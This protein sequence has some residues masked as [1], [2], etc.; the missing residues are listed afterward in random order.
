MTPVK[1]DVSLRSDAE[2]RGGGG[3]RSGGLSSD[4]GLSLDL[5]STISLTL[6]AFDKR[7]YVDLI[8]AR[9]AAL[10]RMVRQ[11]A[12]AMGLASAVDAG[13]G[14]GFFAQTLAEMGL[15]VRGFDGRVENVMEARRRFPEIAF[16]RGDVESAEIADFGKFDLVLCFGLLYHLENPMR[17]IRNLRALTGK[18]LLVESMCV[19][20]DGP[21][22]TLREEPSQDDQSLTD[23]AFYPSEDCLVKMLYRAGFANVY[24]LVRLPEHDDF[25]ETADHSRRRTMLLATPGSVEAPCVERIAEPRE[26]RDPWTKLSAEPESLALRVRRFLEKPGRMRYISLANR[27][28]RLFP[29]M[30]IPLRLPFGA[31]WLAENSALDR[32]LIY[33]GFESAET[34][35]V[36]KFLKPGMTVLDIGAHHGLYTLLASKRVG[37]RGRVIAFEPSPRERRRLMRHVR[38]NRCKNVEVE[39]IALGE[40]AGE[41]DLFLVEG[42]HDWCNSLRPPD[43]DERTTTVRVEVRPLDDVL[44]VLG[45]SRVDFIKLD[46][47]GAELSFLHGAKHLLEGRVRPAILAEVQDIRTRPWGYAAREIIRFLADA[48]YG[49]FALAEDGSLESVSSELPSYD[50]NLV[51]LPHE[52]F[53]EFSVSGVGTPRPRATSRPPSE[54]RPCRKAEFVCG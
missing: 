48:N 20:G 31:W 2:R 35:F 26:P 19:P 39:A 11:L 8:R 15:H 37:R 52:R 4:S 25:R 18:G 1:A 24:R 9:G 22:L 21:R 28:R 38:V 45:V 6:T 42:L 12:P 51:A 49:W 23:T 46:V 7:H 30:P 29:R 47:E 32:E 41:A 43:I 54:T 13:C 10:R 16:H 27:A 14:V 33:N 36:G 34:D 53:E 17:A 3:S 5:A 40:R 50:G 44:R